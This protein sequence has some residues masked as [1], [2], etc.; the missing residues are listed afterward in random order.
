MVQLLA[1]GNPWQMNVLHDGPHNRDTGCFCCER[2]NLIRSLSYIAKKTFNG[3]GGANVAVHHVG[4]VVI[5]QKMT[6]DLAD[7]LGIP[8]RE[9]A[10]HG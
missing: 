2:V 4:K 1:D 10:H 8:L 9:V 6:K 5:G 3:I 7:L